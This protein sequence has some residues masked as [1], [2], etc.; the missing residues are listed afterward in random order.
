VAQAGGTWR[1]YEESMPSD[2]AS[3]DTGLYAKRHN[4]AAYYVS[5]RLGCRRWDVAMGTTGTGALHRA[6]TRTGLPTFSFIT[7]NLCH[8][9]HDC[10]PSAADSWLAKWVPRL[11]ATRDYGRGRTVIFILTEEGGHHGKA[12]QDCLT[13]SSLSCI[14]PLVVVSRS[15]RRGTVSRLPFTH[16]SL[17]RTTQ[18]LLRAGPLLGHA[19]DPSTRSLA[20]AFHLG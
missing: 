11:A 3:G 8:D 17:L 12:G 10:A 2:C 19:S 6:I 16:Y 18:H 14:V 15:T 5:L 7:P 4:P 1:S 9:M 13:S 20:Q